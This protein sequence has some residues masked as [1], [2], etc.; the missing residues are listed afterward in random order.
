MYL[1][2]CISNV[3]HLIPSQVGFLA[4]EGQDQWAAIGPKILNRSKFHRFPTW[5]KSAVLSKSYDRIYFTNHDQTVPT[6][7][8]LRV[9][10][11]FLCLCRGGGCRYPLPIIIFF[12]SAS[13]QEF[14]NINLNPNELLISAHFSLVLIPE[15]VQSERC[16]ILIQ[17]T[18]VRLPSS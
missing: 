6:E 9:D 1:I 7:M 18:V 10:D 5:T 12:W 2:S 15:L 3:L 13:N 4:H 16:S 8:L 14:V 17:W 11:K